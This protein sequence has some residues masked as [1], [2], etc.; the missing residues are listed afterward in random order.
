MTL[1]LELFDSLS[2]EKIA[3]ATDKGRDNWRGTLEWR[4]SVSNRSDAR[5]LMKRW[6][7]GLTSTLE[8]THASATASR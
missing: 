8:D 3:T 7:K 4:T 5:R 2:N 1:N 6:A